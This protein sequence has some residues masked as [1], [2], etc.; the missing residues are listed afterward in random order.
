MVRRD[1]SSGQSRAESDLGKSELFE[2]SAITKQFPILFSARQSEVAWLSNMS[3]AWFNLDGIYWKSVEHFYQAAKFL[4]TFQRDAI[5]SADTPMEAMKIGRK[6]K[7]PIRPDW[8]EIRCEVMVRAVRA[9][10]SQNYDLR[11]QLLKTGDRELIENTNNSFWGRGA[12]GSG[13]NKLG[14]I[15]MKLRNDLRVETDTERIDDCKNFADQV[16]FRK[17]LNLPA[18]QTGTHQYI[19]DRVREVLLGFLS[20]D[21][22]VEELTRSVDSCSVELT[23]GAQHHSFWI[24]QGDF[25]TLGDLAPGAIHW[26]GTAAGPAHPQPFITVCVTPLGVGEAY[27]FV[28]LEVDG[29]CAYFDWGGNDMSVLL[30]ATHGTTRGDAQPLTEPSENLDEL[31]AEMIGRIEA[32]IL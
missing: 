29:R 4:D 26:L 25:E 8:D 12:D 2:Q 15:L 32:S 31:F 19:V 24:T 5:R 1:K 11:A 22:I 13:E 6:S 14:K 28:R 17:L 18:K 20:A 3:L 10:F 30:S 27:A 7:S 16:V 21:C 9:K 23:R